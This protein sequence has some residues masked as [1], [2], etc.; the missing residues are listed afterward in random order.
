MAPTLHHEQVLYC[1]KFNSNKVEINQIVV[2][3]F[4][5]KLL[6]K[7]VVGIPL[8]N[9]E[10]VDQRIYAN[11]ELVFTYSTKTEQN[12]KRELKD[13]EV[14][15]IGDNPYNSLDSRKLGPIKISEIKYRVRLRFWPPRI[16]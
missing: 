2:F 11:E 15:L 12:Y 16:F 3:E 6:I 1:T 9:V 13:N 5:E 10:I 14:Y 8:T 7:R 4:K